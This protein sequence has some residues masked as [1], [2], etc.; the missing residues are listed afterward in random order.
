MI[1]ASRGHCSP[2]GS[3]EHFII[4]LSFRYCFP[5]VLNNLLPALGWSPRKIPGEDSE[6]IRI[7]Q[8]LLSVNGIAE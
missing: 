5:R 6:F 2:I 8:I 7:S 1:M 4:K 3:L